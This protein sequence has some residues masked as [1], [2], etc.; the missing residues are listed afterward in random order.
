MSFS[1]VE[2]IMR[3]ANDGLQRPNDFG[4]WGSND[5]FVTWGF[6]G[7]DKHRDSKILDLSNFSVI[8][9]NLMNRFPDDFR[10]EGFGHWAVGHTDRLVVRILKQD[11]P[12]N[13]ENITDAFRA[14]MEWQDELL[15]Y[16]VANDEHYSEMIYQDAIEIIRDIPSYL[17][18][19]IREDAE[20]W[21]D[22]VW[23]YLANYEDLIIDSDAEL[24]P[25]DHQILAGIFHYGLMVKDE[26]DT[27]NSWNEY[28]I[29]NN[30]D[31]LIV[32]PEK[33]MQMNPLQSTLFDF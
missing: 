12:V 25:D 6:C 14:A 11:G 17:K 28:C 9:R 30:Y 26:D 19:L 24:Y 7:I 8:T 2:N 23:Q 32:T 20:D 16:P 27:Y 21:E 31:N 29:E 1:Y 33:I 22:L 4:Y 13:E 10:I 15:D 18:S 5:T 3:C